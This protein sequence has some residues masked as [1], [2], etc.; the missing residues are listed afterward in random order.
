[1]ASSGA[2]IFFLWALLNLL[3]AEHIRSEPVLEQQSNQLAK[4]SL[5]S[6]HGPA[7]VA[8]ITQRT[9]GRNLLK[10]K[11]KKKKIKVNGSVNTTKNMEPATVRFSCGV[12]KSVIC[13]SFLLLVY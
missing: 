1:M 9:D 6:S 12:L 4:S 7:L 10:K 2:S 3:T 5:R 11:K 8:D 13:A